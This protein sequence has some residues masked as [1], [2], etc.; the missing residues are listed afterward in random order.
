MLEPCLQGQLAADVDEAHDLVRR[1]LFDLRHEQKRAGW[2]EVAEA[3]IRE[4]G[5]SGNSTFNS[6]W[7]AGR[8]AS[9]ASPRTTRP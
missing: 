4:I 2:R 7:M 6:M 9:I 1:L 3:D 5:P 8:G